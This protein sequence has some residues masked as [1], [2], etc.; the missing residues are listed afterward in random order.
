MSWTAGGSNVFTNNYSGSASAIV[1]DICATVSTG[2]LGSEVT[3]DYVFN[4]D[5]GHDYK[6]HFFVNGIPNRRGVAIPGAQ[7]SANFIGGVECCCVDDWLPTDGTSF[8]G[9]TGKTKDLAT[10][11][12][13]WLN[14]W[15]EDMHSGTSSKPWNESYNVMFDL[16]GS[17][18]YTCNYTDFYQYYEGLN[19][20][21]LS[22]THN[23]MKYSFTLGT[24]QFADLASE[25]PHEGDGLVG[26]LDLLY[27]LQNWG[28]HGKADLNSDQKV[29]TADMILLLNNWT[30]PSYATSACCIDGVCSFRSHQ[31][32]ESLGGTYMWT[33][34][35]PSDPSDPNPCG[36]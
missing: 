29:N 9:F 7:Y 27:L 19:P 10:G 35:D 2:V 21:F 13:M 34:C 12:L 4:G 33:N 31:D 5:S 26:I 6:G 28:D 22:N 20:G 16:L 23:Y 25:T 8:A 3:I 32:C 24:M 36:S 1:R 17:E 11:Q 15:F 14:N 18:V 30:G